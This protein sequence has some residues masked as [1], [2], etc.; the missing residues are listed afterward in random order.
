MQEGS[1]KARSHPRDLIVVDGAVDN[2]HGSV[3]DEDASA[4]Q[5]VEAVR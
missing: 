3:I 4:L 1:R 5:P 2:A